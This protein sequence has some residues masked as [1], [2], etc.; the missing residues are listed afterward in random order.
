MPDMKTR[1][2]ESLPGDHLTKVCA[3]A[4]R[5]AKAETCIVEFEFNE[6]HLK[7]TPDT[8]AAT[9]IAA[10]DAACEAARIAYAASPECKARAEA[11]EERERERAAKVAELLAIA[12]ANMTLKDEAGWKLS[13]EKNPDPYG[14]AVNTYAERWARLMEARMSKGERIG[15]IA[16]ECSHLADEE[17]ITGFMYGCA[18]GILSH[19]WI[20]G[21]ALRLWHNLKSGGAEQ[22]KKA[23]DAGAVINPAI[24]TIGRA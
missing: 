13:V 7:A 1:I 18:V 4:V 23:N 19:V 14:S 24:L 20:H 12:P 6:I 9:L 16:D 8:E 3:E 2:L 21:E 5:I 22:G 11:A 10:Y 15:D 17:G